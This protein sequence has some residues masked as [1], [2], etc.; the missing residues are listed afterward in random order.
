MACR[1]GRFDFYQCSIFWANSAHVEQWKRHIGFRHAQRSILNFLVGSRY[2]QQLQPALSAVPP[3]ASRL[4]ADFICK[5]GER[6][7]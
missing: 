3:F 5:R 2:W 1:L 7:V 6:Q 4:G